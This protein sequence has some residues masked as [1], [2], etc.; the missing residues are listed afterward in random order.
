MDRSTASGRPHPC[1]ADDYQDTEI[2][3]C[4]PGHLPGLRA[5]IG[6]RVIN[7]DTQALAIG[8]VQALRARAQLASIDMPGNLAREYR[9]LVLR[10]LA[11]TED[12]TWGEVASIYDAY[13]E[14]SARYGLG[15]C[16]K[17]V[18]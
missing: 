16:G 10:A 15:L 12:T 11:V 8:V 5:D 7:P 13:L 9:G 17:E 2:I 1:D 18:N 3:R 6:V 4:G 14:R